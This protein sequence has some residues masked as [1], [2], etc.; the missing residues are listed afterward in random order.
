MKNR[1][2][3]EQF[4]NNMIEGTIN[5][6]L[7]LTDSCNFLRP[8]IFNLPS[9][10]FGQGLTDPRSLSKAV[11]DDFNRRRFHGPI[12][13]N[14]PGNVGIGDVLLDHGDLEFLVR[15]LAFMD[16]FIAAFKIQYWYHVFIMLGAIGIIV[17]VVFDLKGIA[18]MHALLF[19]LG[20]F[21]IGIGE[22]INH[23][24]QTGI[25]RPNVYAPGGGIITG[26]PRKN[27]FSGVMFDL[28]GALF[29]AAAIYKIIKVI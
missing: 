12:F 27:I 20:V 29:F 17:A 10:G 11:C 3:I 25:L 7:I 19:F 6:G 26:H 14:H 24:L 23:P 1:K 4:L 28:V 15:E 21:L 2:N 9:D 5:A 13:S 22:W 8:E 16:K 18:N